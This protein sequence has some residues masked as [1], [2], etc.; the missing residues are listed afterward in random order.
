MDDSKSS[1]VIKPFSRWWVRC[2]WNMVLFIFR[3]I[4]PASCLHRWLPTGVIWR[5]ARRVC[6]R[7]YKRLE[8]IVSISLW[9]LFYQTITVCVILSLWLNYLYFSIVFFFLKTMGHNLT[10]LHVLNLE[11]FWNALY[12]L[13]FYKCW[14]CMVML[15]STKYQWTTSSD[16]QKS[17]Q[18][19]IIMFEGRRLFYVIL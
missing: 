19:S 17:M 3:L 15:T 18:T 16:I 5:E 11:F 12:F 8:S 14:L 10:N 1:C 4:L 7:Y 9:S 6:T 2:T 13:C